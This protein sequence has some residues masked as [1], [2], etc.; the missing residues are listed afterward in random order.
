M[1]PPGYL[2]GEFQQATW[3]VRLKFKRQSRDG[4]LES[5]STA[6]IF[7]ITLLPRQRVQKIRTEGQGPILWECF[8]RISG[9]KASRERN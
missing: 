2:N 9:E 6:E 4:N 7:E 1:M 5:V 3:N 8:H